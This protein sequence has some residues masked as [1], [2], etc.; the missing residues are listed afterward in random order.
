MNRF[1]RFSLVALG[2]L[3]AS[4]LFV[5][6]DLFATPGK[7][8]KLSVLSATTSGTSARSLF[9]RALTALTNTSTATEGY[10][11]SVDAE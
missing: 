5:S 8:G 9:E 3:V 7:P 1:V 2:L 11:V 10:I 6:C 4:S